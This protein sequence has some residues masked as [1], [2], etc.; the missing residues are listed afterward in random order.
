MRARALIWAVIGA[1]VTAAGTLVVF[2]LVRGL[3][4]AGWLAGVL[5]AF[6]ALAALVMALPHPAPAPVPPPTPE[7][8]GEEDGATVN[9]FSGGTA[10]GPVVMGRDITFTGRPAPPTGSDPDEEPRD[11][12]GPS[13]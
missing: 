9:T 1:A 11:G 8:P 7:R 12:A 10:H 2:W 4:Q 3:E 13:R 5:G 6:A